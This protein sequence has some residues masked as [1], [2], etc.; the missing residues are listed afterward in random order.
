MYLQE[1]FS[2]DDDAS[3]MSSAFDIPADPSSVF[4]K[5]SARRSRKRAAAAMDDFQDEEEEEEDPSK[6]PTI[7]QLNARR[8]K[9][10]LSLLKR[11]LGKAQKARNF[12]QKERL[13]A[14]KRAARE[15]A[16]VVRQRATAS[17]RAARETTWRAKR[18]T[19]EMQ[20]HWRRYDRVEKQQRRQQE[21]EAEEQLKMDVQLL[22]AK[23]QQ[24]K[25]NFLITQT[26]L[27]AHFIQKKVGG[28]KQEG[29]QKEEEDQEASILDR[30]GEE[31]A[32]GRLA[33]IDDYDA[34]AAQE[35]AK[36]SASAAVEKQRERTGSFERGLEETREKSLQGRSR[37]QPSLFRGTLKSYQLRGMNWLM[38]LYDQGI[39]GILA[40][41]MGL[42]KTVQSLAMLAHIAE[43]YSECLQ[44]TSLFC[45]FKEKIFPRFV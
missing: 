27:Y 24:R 16:K 45:V 9:C 28:G 43:A 20:A 33:E 44:I 22:E 8:R 17:Q 1:P 30:L 37:E 36:I 3:N 7:E 41:E 11:E 5:F 10:W 12:N 2:K 32:E 14:C 21:K 26:E 39:N 6:P 18:L 15:C 40:D 29:G 35:A 38:D 4:S 23:R 25:L 31:K 13:Q 34:A 42:G 19:R